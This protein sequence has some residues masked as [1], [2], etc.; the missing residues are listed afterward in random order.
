MR[1]VQVA[2]ERKRYLDLLLLADEQES[3]IDRYLGRGDMFLMTDG[4]GSAI[5]VAVVVREHDGVCELKNLAVTPSCQGRGY[6]RAMIE[7]ICGRY[8]GICSEL[9]VGTGDTPSTVGFYERCGF[10][11]SHIIPGFFT[12]N[13]DRPIWDGGILLEDMVYLKRPLADRV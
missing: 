11:R 10:V 8:A 13:Y 2:K 6:G 3:M 1:I 5:A 9:L 4:A 12:D 7:Y